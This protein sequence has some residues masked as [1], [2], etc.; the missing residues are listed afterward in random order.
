MIVARRFYFDASHH[1]PEY[2]GACERVH[3]HTYRLEVEVSGEQRRD[4][5][6][7]DF[8]DL[9]KVVQENVLDKLDHE[10]LNK[11]LEN[12]TAENICD[13]IW[14]QLEGEVNLHKVRLWEGEGKWVEKTK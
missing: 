12:P 7:L 13:W 9:K 5:M 4:G 6:V 11:V 2:K 1:L 8:R 3:G 10:N 14:T